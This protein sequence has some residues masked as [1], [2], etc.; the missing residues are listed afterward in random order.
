MPSEDEALQWVSTE[1]SAEWLPSQ[2]AVVQHTRDGRTDIARGVTLIQGGRH[3]IEYRIYLAAHNKRGYGVVV[4][5]SDAEAPSWNPAPVGAAP[6]PKPSKP[7]VAWGICV[8]SGRLISTQDAR[9]GQFGG[10]VLGDA[11]VPKQ[12]ME[13]AAQLTVVVEVDI[14]PHAS[15]EDAAVARRDIPAT[16]GH[17]LDMAREFPLHMKP[18]SSRN[19]HY[20]TGSPISKPSSLSFSVNDGPMVDAGVRLPAGVYPWVQL[21]GQGDAVELVSIKNLTPPKTTSK[22]ESE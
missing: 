16:Y 1:Q 15:A 10:G 22:S 14:P 17:P 12:A 2:D 9:A 8:S 13:Q 7:S 21:T 20:L 4:G 3:R 5:V 18:M 6:K 19:V 11:L